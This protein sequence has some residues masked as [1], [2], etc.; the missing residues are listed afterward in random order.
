MCVCRLLTSCLC[1]CRVGGGLHRHRR[2]RSIADRGGGEVSEARL[3]S[4]RLPGRTAAVA[5]RVLDDGLVKA[6]TGKSSD[7]DEQDILDL[8]LVY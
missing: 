4:H 8:L 1:E 5:E 6:D 2:S 7:E 3:S